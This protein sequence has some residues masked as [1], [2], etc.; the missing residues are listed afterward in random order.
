MTTR[1]KRPRTA[2]LGPLPPWRLDPIVRD[3]RRRPEQR[4]AALAEAYRQ[5]DAAL[6]QIWAEYDSGVN[7][8]WAACRAACDDATSRY[9][10]KVALIRAGGDP[11]PGLG[12]RALMAGEARPEDPDGG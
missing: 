10:S 6:A 4:D 1:S 9:A 5:L 7:A 11:Y 3:Q 2:R 12:P 8:L